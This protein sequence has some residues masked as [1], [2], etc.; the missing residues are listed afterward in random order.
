MLFARAAQR[1]R[2]IEAFFLGVGAGGV[3]RKQLDQT[4]EACWRILEEATGHLRSPATAGQQTVTDAN[5]LLEWLRAKEEKT[6]GHIVQ[7][8]KTLRQLTARR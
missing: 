7:V 5:S 3:Q 4:G 6:E 2:E 8:E 1:A